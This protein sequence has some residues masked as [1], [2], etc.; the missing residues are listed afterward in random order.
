MGGIEAAA[1]DEEEEEENEELRI[2]DILKKAVHLRSA[3][4]K[5][6]AEEWAKRQD[7][8]QL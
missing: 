3:K 1:E 8:F 4:E 2:W 6:A 5:I 7:P